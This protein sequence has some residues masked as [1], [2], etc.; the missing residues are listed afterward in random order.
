[1]LFNAVKLK[2]PEV[3]IAIIECSGGSSRSLPCVYCEQKLLALGK[4]TMVQK[5]FAPENPMMK[6]FVKVRSV[7]WLFVPWSPIRNIVARAV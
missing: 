6:A 5:A 4:T 2:N 3:L 7:A 1:M